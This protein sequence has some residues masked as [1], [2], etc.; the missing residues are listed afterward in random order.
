MREK[1]GGRQFVW[2]KV[3]KL[4]CFKSQKFSPNMEFWDLHDSLNILSFK[5]KIVLFV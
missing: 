5:K 4:A 1:W 3:D 2:M